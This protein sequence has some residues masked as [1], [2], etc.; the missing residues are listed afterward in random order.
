MRLYLHLI[1]VEGVSETCFQATKHLHFD[2]GLH[3]TECM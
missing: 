3:V 2:S 1:N